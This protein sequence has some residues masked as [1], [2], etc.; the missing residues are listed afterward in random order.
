MSAILL[1]PSTLLPLLR[2]CVVSVG[3]AILPQQES[4]QAERPIRQAEDK[5]GNEGPSGVQ[6]GQGEE[7]GAGAGES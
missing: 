2:V 6:E 4:I 1:F 7:D 5:P 3:L